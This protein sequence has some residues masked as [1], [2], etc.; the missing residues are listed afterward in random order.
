MNRSFSVE[1]HR[2]NYTIRWR[3]CQRREHHHR[4]RRRHQRRPHP[5]LCR[6][7]AV[8]PFI[9]HRKQKLT[10][11]YQWHKIQPESWSEHKTHN[12]KRMVRMQKGKP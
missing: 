7:A 3:I 1:E 4:R 6:R 2:T 8:I 11:N 12:P 10:Q 9:G 5:H